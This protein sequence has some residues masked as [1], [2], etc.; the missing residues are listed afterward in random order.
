[1]FKVLAKAPT[2]IDLAGGTLDLW[3]IH[4]VLSHKATV[5]IGITLEARVELTPSE[6]NYFQLKSQDQSKSFVGDFRATTQSSDL[7]LI[8]L[9]LEALWHEG[10]PALKITTKAQSPAGAGLGGSSCLGITL[11]GALVRARSLVGDAIEVSEYELVRIVRD[12]ESRL[13]HSPAGIQDYWGAVRGQVN[14]LNFPPGFV[15]V[16]TL[17]ADSV[18]GL[19]SELILCFSGKSRQ[20]AI[21]NWEIFKRV[22]DRDKFLIET[23]NQ[24]GAIAEQC[25][26]VAKLGNL[27]TMLELSHQEWELRV[28][29]WPN[30]ETPETKRLDAAARAA[31]AHFSRVCGA[32]GGGV[33]AVFA[34]ADLRD[35]VCAALIENAGVILDATVAT[36]GLIVESIT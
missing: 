26:E 18:R 24:I 11:A 8:G 34:P 10:L 16:Q 2:R 30:I 20:S 22:F 32:G 15:H 21:N 5:N 4:Q 27:A 6:T 14:L 25:A 13:I 3:P 28:K 35:K 31:G 7:P 19:A 17:S 29:L 33:M 12:V 23:L 1:M 9:L 36:T